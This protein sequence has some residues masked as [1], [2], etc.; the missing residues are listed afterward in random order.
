MLLDG[1]LRIVCVV[2]SQKISVE[3]RKKEMETQL[4]DHV[5]EAEEE[6]KE[7]VIKGY[8]SIYNVIQ[9]LA[10][11]YITFSILSKL[12]LNGAGMF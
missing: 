8:L 5:R 6:V 7:L 12:L 2:L 11:F 10:F 3:H 1:L 9:S 4:E